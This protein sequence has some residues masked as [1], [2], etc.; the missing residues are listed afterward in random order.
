MN[1]SFLMFSKMLCDCVF[2]LFLAGT[3]FRA[4]AG[5]NVIRRNKHVDLR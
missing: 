1:V 4:Q 5:G 2:F 3:S